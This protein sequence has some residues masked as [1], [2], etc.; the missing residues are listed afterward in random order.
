[1]HLLILYEELAWYFVNCLNSL[2]ESKG[3]KIL[4]F[5]KQIN[6]IAPFKFNFIHPHVTIVYREDYTDETLLEHCR[7]F[8]PQMVYLGGWSYKPYIYLI[9]TL[10]LPNTVIGF[11]NQYTGSLKQLL[12]SIYFRLRLKPYIKFAFVPGPQQVEFAKKI[13]FKNDCIE[14][15]AYCC[16]TELFTRYY[17]ENVTQKQSAFPKRFLFVGRYADEKGISMLWECFTEIHN[18]APSEWELWCIGKGHVTPFLHPKIKHFGFLQPEELGNV[19]SNTGVFVLPST[20]EPWGV[21]LHEYAAAGFPLLTTNKVGA[22]T[23]FL[24]NSVNGYVIDAGH[25][26]QLKSKLKEFMAMS[27]KNLNLMAEN[28][29]KMSTKITPLKW[30][31]NLMN[32]YAFKQN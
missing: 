30:A 14:Q 18:E 9:K 4:V 32:L 28:S 19:I 31:E 17:A 11:D 7:A 1:M 23:V 6:S 13:G 27:D 16:D 15:G 8:S 10:A 24:Q 26:Q 12:G 5:S 21:V 3:V 25:K 2:A 29:V 20:F 22:S